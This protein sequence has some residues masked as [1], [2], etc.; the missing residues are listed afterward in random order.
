MTEIPTLNGRSSAQ[1]FLEDH[2]RVTRELMI[3]RD[4]TQQTK[5]LLQEA[6]MKNDFLWQ[7]NHRLRDQVAQERSRGDKYQRYCVAMSSHLTAVEESFKRAHQMGLEA[8]Q[9]VVQK[10]TDPGV[11]GASQEE[12]QRLVDLATR[13]APN[14][15][16]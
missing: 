8:A 9:E 12:H 5:E 13:L 2:D 14:K 11:T 10:E 15:M 4:E 16:G 6:L 1:K 7:E 3:S